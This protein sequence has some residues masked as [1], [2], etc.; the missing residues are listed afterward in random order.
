[1]RKPLKLARRK[2]TRRNSATRFVRLVRRDSQGKN[3]KEGNTT[4]LGGGSGENLRISWGFL[5]CKRKEGRDARSVSVPVRSVGGGRA[6]TPRRAPMPPALREE[7]GGNAVP[8]RRR[9]RGGEEEEGEGA[10]GTTNV[11]GRDGDKIGGIG[12]GSGRGEEFA[13]AGMRK[14]RAPPR[15]FVGCRC[16]GVWALCPRGPGVSGLLGVGGGEGI[17]EF[18]E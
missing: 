11:G 9:T 14:G 17:G 3:C 4:V 13:A 18:G 1:M 7:A 12:L 15:I 8:I 5:T 2:R 10:A 6:A 16:L